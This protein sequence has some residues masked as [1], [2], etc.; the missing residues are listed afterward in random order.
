MAAWTKILIGQRL[1]AGPG[2]WPRR[3]LHLAVDLQSDPSTP[4]WFRGLATLA[5]LCGLT[6]LLSPNRLPFDSRPTKPLPADVPLP[7]R[8]IAPAFALPPEAGQV[9]PIPTRIP[10]FEEG[11]VRF[12]GAAGGSLYA[13]LSA[14][15][16][17]F[18]VI[19]EYLEALSSHL[20]FRQGLAADA[21]YDLVVAYHRDAKGAGRF[22]PLLYAGLMQ[23]DQQLQLLP[24]PRQN[25]PLWLDAGALGARRLTMV[26]PV[27]ATRVSSGFGLRFHPLLGFSRLHKGIDFAAP[28][29]AAVRAVRDGVVAHS[30]W[31]GGNGQLVRLRHAGALGSGY[32]H[33]SQLY[34]SPG[35]QVRQGEV[36]GLVGATGLATGPHLHF[37]VY[38]DGEAVDPAG[39]RFSPSAALSPA[40]QSVLRARLARLTALPIAASGPPLG[41]AGGG[42]E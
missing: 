5:F 42:P 27:S 10:F 39:V 15:G 13:A 37:E 20:D 4:G 3:S 25:V 38:R 11:P 31:A 29:G 18:S 22:G 24:W 26:S 9:A 7:H 1:A 32:A 21:Q 14:Q 33:L 23:R 12:R 19:Q 2:L 36:I 34:V 8:T 6:L 17:P 40:A 30:G 41:A 35:Q 28:Y 16:L